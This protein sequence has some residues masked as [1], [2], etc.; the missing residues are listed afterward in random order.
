MGVIKREDIIGWKDVNGEMICLE[1]GDQDCKPLT[2][3]D[4]EDDD[5]V[6]C[7]QVSAIGICGKR[8]Q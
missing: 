6:T 1:C 7:D 5:Y 4:F 3:D 8:I 2:K